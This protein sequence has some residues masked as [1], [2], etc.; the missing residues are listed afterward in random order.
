MIFQSIGLANDIFGT[1]EI[2]PLKKPITRK[3]LDFIFPTLGFPVSAFVSSTFWLIYAIDR[4]LIHPQRLDAVIPSWVNHTRHTFIIFIVFLELLTRFR[5]FPK[6][7]YAMIAITILIVSYFTT[8]FT[9]KYLTN[10]WMYPVMA[11]MNNVQRAV[12]IMGII[13]YGILLYFIGKLINNKFWAN[14]LK[15]KDC[16][17]DTDSNKKLNE[18]ENA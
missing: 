10:Y 8:I 13:S 1:N 5:R 15:S 17:S 3:I 9:V 2:S 11:A 6:T 14:E 18:I 7:R 4:E 12:F 16:D